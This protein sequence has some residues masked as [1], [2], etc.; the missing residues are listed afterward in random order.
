MWP[1]RRSTAIVHLVD[2]LSRID[3]SFQK[4]LGEEGISL[5][6]RVDGIGEDVRNTKCLGR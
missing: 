4:L 1:T 6:P 2:E 3:Q 5:R